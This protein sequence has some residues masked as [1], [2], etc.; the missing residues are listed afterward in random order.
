MGKSERRKEAA[1]T[2][3]AIHAEQESYHGQSAQP[4]ATHPNG[5]HL[6]ISKSAKPVSTGLAKL[7]LCLKQMG[8]KQYLALY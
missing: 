2:S 1:H 8:L 6:C 4:A 3:I 7:L 5:Q